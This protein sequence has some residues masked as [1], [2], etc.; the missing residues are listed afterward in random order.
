MIH[1]VNEWEDGVL[2]IEREDGEVGFDVDGDFASD[3]DDAFQGSIA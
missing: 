1:W 3:Q 2:D